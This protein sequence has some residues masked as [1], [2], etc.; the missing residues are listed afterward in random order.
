MLASSF[1][2]RRGS[3][4]PEKQADAASGKTNAHRS[5]TILRIVTE[6]A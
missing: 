3:S 5:V 2:G 4:G 1:A 6:T